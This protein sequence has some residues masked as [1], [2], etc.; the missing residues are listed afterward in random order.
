ML[1]GRIFGNVFS[2][3]IRTETVRFDILKSEV[4]L[5]GTRF[6]NNDGSD[7]VKYERKSSYDI[8]WT[9]KIVFRT[10][11]PCTRFREWNSVTVQSAVVIVLGR[12]DLTRCITIACGPAGGF[13]FAVV[14][15]PRQTGGWRNALEGAAA[16]STDSS[17]GYYCNNNNTPRVPGPIKT[18]DQSLHRNSFAFPSRH[19][20]PRKSPGT[21]TP[22]S[23]S[24]F[25]DDSRSTEIFRTNRTPPVTRVFSADAC[26]YITERRLDRP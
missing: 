11:T 7:N 13:A 5:R 20:H 22:A 25:D 26:N 12:V 23:A 14:R 19:R 6:D 9:D 15:T 2:F 3:R 18:R 24:G 10:I 1:T 4:Y 8:R 16:E 17:C 21:G